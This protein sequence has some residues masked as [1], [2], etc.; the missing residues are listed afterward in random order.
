MVYSEEINHKPRRILLINHYAGSPEHGMEYRN[1]F[2]SREWVR[3]GHS[4][5]I[6]AGAYSH[7]RGKQ[8]IAN[9]RFITQRTAEHIDGIEYVW[10]PT[11]RYQGNGV[12]RVL[13]IW[14]FLCQVW[15][16]CARTVKEFQPNIVIASSTY[17]LDI[18]VAKHMARLAKAKLV[19]EVHDLWP[20]SPIELGGM[21]PHHPFIYLCQWAENTAYRD[22]DVVISMLPKVREHMSAHGLDLRKLHIIPNGVSLD[23]WQGEAQPIG[24]ELAL[25]IQTCKER[26][27]LLV[28]YAGSHGV[29]NA[30]D[31][32]LDAAKI[33]TDKPISFV[34]IG[35][36]HEKTRL[37]QRVKDERL[38][39]VKMFAPIPKMQ[40]PTVL[41]N[42]DLAFLGAL[43]SPIY[44]FGV[45]P[46]KLMD[47][48]MAGIP[49]MY[50]I[51]ASND[52]VAEA[53]C[54]ISVPAND[55]GALAFGIQR[56]M[57]IENAER[58]AMGARGK[59]YVMANLTYEALARQFL[60]AVT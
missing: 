32:L 42:F 16:D 58:A 41:K 8:P 34:L 51:E 11:P 56:F 27:C 49:V 44:R 53:G 35:D 7:L 17:P 30:L 29:P 43:K 37:Q 46:N 24:E 55:A 52:L 40:I 31:N 22:A 1:Y 5:R 9:G 12:K 47:Y 3:A 19:F 38:M 48:M 14:A 13:N 50:A 15:V 21:S 20:L 4:V 18:W 6:L 54:G 60:N 36:G 45:S 39:N 59:E 23:G 33:L 28:G 2:L 26:G 57:K 25:H 10:Y